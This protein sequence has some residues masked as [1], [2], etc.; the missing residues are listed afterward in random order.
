MTNIDDPGRSNSETFT[1]PHES[2]AGSLAQF[3]QLI[4]QEL[5]CPSDFLK[6]CPLRRHEQATIPP[7]V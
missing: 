5:I 4:L 7:R 2:S 1:V 6:R 3:V